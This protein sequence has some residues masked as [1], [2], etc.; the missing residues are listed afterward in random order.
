MTPDI[1][2]FLLEADRR[3]PDLRITNTSMAAFE[4]LQLTLALAGPDWQHVGKTRLDGSQVA[5]PGFVPF[6]MVL[7]RPDGQP[8]TERVTGVSQD[9]AWHVP[10]RRQIKVIAFSAANDPGPWEHGPAKLTPYEIDPVHYRW[11][12]PAVPQF[13]H[14][15]EPLPTPR[16]QPTPPPS[17]VLPKVEAY[18]QLLA[19]NA[20]YAADDGLQR[21]GGLVRFDDQ[22]R[23]IADM[24]AIAQWFYQLVIEGIPLEQVFTQIRAS[25]EWRSKHP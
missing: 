2:P 16:P 5:P 21:A 8:V 11:H 15:A 17:R 7:T 22:G 6:E 9:A 24:E 19:L 1:L 4:L 12:N 14:V 3:R 25:Q 13:G 23:T 10:S 20:F 18:Q